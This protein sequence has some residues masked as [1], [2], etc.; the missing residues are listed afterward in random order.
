MFN[1]GDRVVRK[2]ENLIDTAFEEGRVMTVTDS[3]QRSNGSCQI[4]IDPD[5]DN[6]DDLWWNAAAFDF[7]LDHTTHIVPT[8]LESP[9]TVAKHVDS[10]PVDGGW[11]DDLT[12]GKTYLSPGGT[13]KYVILF[14][15]NHGVLAEEDVGVRSYFGFFQWGIENELSQWT[16]LK[17]AK[18]YV[19]AKMRGSDPVWL[20][21]CE[22][23]Q[24]AKARVVK[25]KEKW[26]LSDYIE[27]E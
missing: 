11:Q 27:L 16:E 1:I 21:D 26:D 9:T 14:K 6:D 25:S 7:A 20:C 18:F 13:R 3:R 24:V 8:G 4:K 5:P 17:P 2:P 10:L 23:Q 19:W 12:V 15:D 22:S